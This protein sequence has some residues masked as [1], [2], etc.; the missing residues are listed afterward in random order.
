[1]A[2][3]LRLFEDE[4]KKQKIQK[5]IDELQYE[6]NYDTRDYPISF[7][8]DLYN[9][10]Y[11]IF[12][13][14]YQRNE[15]LWGAK[16]KS[17][18][19]ESLLLDY[20][21]P[22]LFLAD[23]DSGTMEI[24]DGLQRISTLSE[25]FA[26]DLKLVG[27]KKLTELNDCTCEDLP[28]SE[29]RRLKARSLRVIV[30]KHNTPSDVRKELFDRLNT[31][32]LRANTSEVRAGRE[33]DNPLMK[34]I[35]E[36]A[37]DEVFRKTT[38]LSANRVN[39]KEDIELVTRFFAYSNDLDNYTGQVMN[40]VDDFVSSAEEDWSEEK[41]E[42]FREEFQRT[43][44][45]VD[46]NFERGFQK[47]DRNQTPRVR[48]EAISVGVNLALRKQPNLSVTKEQIHKLLTSEQFKIWTTSDAAN[49]SKKVNNRIKGVRDYLLIG[50]FDEQ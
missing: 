44:R 23:T 20:P 2:R 40:F 1:M 48:F 14:E 3:Q 24:V 46:E 12:A 43:M 19:I 31:S 38:N 47:E 18:F 33:L 28:K 25:F 5:Q 13:P 50:R 6:L 32:S 8:V 45:F 4:E 15:L 21:I 37:V 34:L 41:Q 39:R 49:N 16:Q 26:E 42:L 10:E 22:L 35:K 27:L 17:R 30:L 36:L 11:E 9:D 7:I 29:I